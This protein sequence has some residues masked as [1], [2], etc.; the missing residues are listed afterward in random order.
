MIYKTVNFKGLDF[1]VSEDGKT[2]INLVTGNQ[3]KP[4]T[5]PDGYRVCSTHYRGKKINIR[6]HQLVAAAFLGERPD[7]FVVD[8][9]DRNRSNNHY[10]NLRYVS[11]S[12]QNK[13][14]DYT[15][16][17]KLNKAKA[18]LARVVNQK[19]I[20]IFDG[21]F[22]RDFNSVSELAHE[23]AKIRHCSFD[24][25]KKFIFDRMRK[26]EK[27]CGYEII[28]VDYIPSHP[29]RPEH[30]D[31]KTPPHAIPVT[32]S[33]DGKTHRFNSAADAARFISDNAGGNFYTNCDK[34][35]ACIRGFNKYKKTI[36]GFEVICDD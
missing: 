26:G 34:I 32:L 23:I 7:G 29:S 15:N 6:V 25:A 14:R 12:E 28:R 27:I 2:V 21:K 20:S 30:I 4:H 16:I 11:L 36:Q 35:R 13:N 33:K 10:T 9:I 31:R 3:L 24:A 8:H 5:D 19:S 1:Q 22:I 17:N 18:Q